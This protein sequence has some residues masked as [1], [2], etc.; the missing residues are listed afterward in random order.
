MNRSRI[1]SILHIGK[2]YLN[3][4]L[5]EMILINIFKNL[6]NT[7]V[8]DEKFSYLTQTS[9]NDNSSISSILIPVLNAVNEDIIF[10]ENLLLLY[11]KEE[12]EIEF[13]LDSK[14]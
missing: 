11:N 10:N 13:T 14:N 8:S 3:L 6:F 5:K 4:Y 7:K 12:I 9:L 2:D 1:L